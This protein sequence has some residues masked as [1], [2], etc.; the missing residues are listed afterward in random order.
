MGFWAGDAHDVSMLLL[1]RLTDHENV[2]KENTPFLAVKR[3]I[4]DLHDDEDD[5][6]TDWVQD[7]LV[8][9]V[10]RIGLLQSLPHFFFLVGFCIMTVLVVGTYDYHAVSAVRSAVTGAEYP[11]GHDFLRNPHWREEVEDIGEV[12]NIKA[13]FATGF[14]SKTL[15][16]WSRPT[17]VDGVMQ[18]GHGFEGGK[19]YGPSFYGAWWM[20][21]SMRV[22]KHQATP[23]SC[24]YPSEDYGDWL[25]LRRLE[26]PCFG[27]NNVDGTMIIEGGDEGLWRSY[28]SEKAYHTIHYGESLLLHPKDLV[29]PLDNVSQPTN[30]NL[31]IIVDTEWVNPATRLV[32][33]Q[34][35]VFN[36]YG[37][38]F[39]VFEIFFEILPE[40][41][42]WTG[43]RVTPVRLDQ[44][45][46]LLA[47]FILLLFFGILFGFMEVRDAVM[48]LIMVSQETDDSTESRRTCISKMKYCF[49]KV[50]LFFKKW[51]GSD[52]NS[53]DIIV[54]SVALVS[55]SQTY[56]LLNKARDVDRPD[57]LD[58]ER[59]G[60]D[61]KWIHIALD[62]RRL[63]QLLG[64]LGILLW[65]KVP[66]MMRYVAAVGPVIHNITSLTA[67][68][69][70]FGF[71]IVFFVFVI[72][73]LV[74][75]YITL[76]TY[77]GAV[78]S[79]GKAFVN[80]LKMVLGDW[81][82]M[83]VP[84][85]EILA[86][87]Y[88]SSFLLWFWTVVFVNVFFL[89]ILIAVIGEAYSNSRRPGVYLNSLSKLYLKME[90]L[91]PIARLPAAGQHRCCMTWLHG[92]KMFFLGTWISKR[93]EEHQEQ[94]WPE[95]ISGAAAAQYDDEI[96]RSHVQLG[97]LYDLSLQGNKKIE[98]QEGFARLDVK[99][100]ENQMMLK[101][102]RT[103]VGELTTRLALV[104]KEMER[105]PKYLE[106]WDGGVGETTSQPASPL[107]S[108]RRRRRQGTSPP[109]VDPELQ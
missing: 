80:T 84:M 20:L 46:E 71:I 12:N 60:F 67:S 17:A 6:V 48:T 7:K 16:G 76:H 62:T 3:I 42:V 97:D 21:G 28:F 43:D 14:A 109:A 50:K 74:G 98:E 87:G 94:H 58:P 101:E 56:S 26:Y 68:R 108:P 70:V 88:L 77:S 11:G 53:Y 47:L 105:G 49:E 5:T 2:P 55:A 64:W 78:S 89:N 35:V 73:L 8:Q 27:R 30:A 95:V 29:W 106:Y 107:A 104:E 90:L 10:Y 41:I 63:H 23:G 86:D 36:P 99:I 40:G 37:G 51:V 96:E 103:A 69:E 92:V 85:E 39:V 81:E 83:D 31:S 57:L 44:K 32:A 52:W 102:M 15:R 93:F 18:Q 54:F 61:D 25:R 1:S 22:G 4:D 33:L 13:W 72:G 91:I 38:T 34:G 65:F 59:R 82:M 79:P 24:H 100:S 66:S 45:A 75:W 19:P 9:K